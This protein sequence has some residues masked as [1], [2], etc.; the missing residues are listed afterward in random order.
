MTDGYISDDEQWEKFKAWW[1]ANGTFIIVGLAIG[2]AIIGGWRWWEHYQAQR[3]Y[4]ASALYA[5]FEQAL[6]KPAADND[7]NKNG[8]GE[9][10]AIGKNLI[11]NYDDTPYAAQAALGLA[12]A[13]VTANKP[14]QAIQH[15][16]WVV[17]NSDDGSL[18][19]LARLRLARVQIANKQARAALQTLS[20]KD[21]G[22]FASLYA[23]VR[24]DA[25]RALGETAKAHQAY[26]AALAAQADGTGSDPL[27]KLKLQHT[28]GA[29]PAPADK[30]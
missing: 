12:G 25:Y 16:Q 28:A 13:E 3:D 24:G 23:E 27:L 9:A 18:K 29:K 2:L 7:K 22:G 20:V 4:N 17:Q 8:N 15:L 6:N 1:K 21:A 14:D 10:E 11:A 30:S 19:L 5:Q 26:Q